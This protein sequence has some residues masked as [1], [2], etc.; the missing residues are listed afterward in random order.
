MGFSSS[1]IGRHVVLNWISGELRRRTQFGD[2]RSG[3][4]TGSNAWGHAPGRKRAD[5]AEARQENSRHEVLQSKGFKAQTSKGYALQH[6]AIKT[7]ARQK[8][9]RSGQ[10]HLKSID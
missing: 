9:I 4:E 8:S 5:R 6:R 2:P 7:S 10:K 1:P 3:R